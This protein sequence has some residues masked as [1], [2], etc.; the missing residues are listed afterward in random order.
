MSRP[1]IRGAVPADHPA[2]AELLDAS[3]GAQP[4]SRRE[5]QWRWRSEENPAR[6][7]ATPPFLVAEKDGRLVGV[8]GLIPVRLLLDGQEGWGA[9]ACDFA[10]SEAGRAMGMKLKLRAMGKD[11]CDVALSTSA[12]ESARKI[13]LALGGRTIPGTGYRYILPLRPA[14]LRSGGA[15]GWGAAVAERTVG[16]PYR[17]LLRARAR[18]SGGRRAPVP[19][20]RAGPAADAFWREIAPSLGSLVIVRD[21]AYLNWRYFDSPFGEALAFSL[22]RGDRVEA[23][24]IGQLVPD[25]SGHK[26]CVLGELL[27]RRGEESGARALIDAVVAAAIERGADYV[28]AHFSDGPTAD[29]L[30]RRG[31]WRRGGSGGDFTV[32][33]NRGAQEEVLESPYLSAGDG[34]CSFY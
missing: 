17:L 30:R 18:W 7:D 29:L 25:T 4:Y 11:V 10:V 24:A 8:H 9:C 19:L 6:R 33:V 16:G 20:R 1:S 22:D 32:K 31:F 3:F 28:Y 13:T 34:D 5:A 14:A 27:F 2:I 21:A 26:A 23:L 12:S 15:A